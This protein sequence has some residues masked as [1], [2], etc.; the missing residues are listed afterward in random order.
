MILRKSL[1][2]AVRRGL[3][4]LQGSKLHT[5]AKNV[6]KASPQL[7]R[8][9]KALVAGFP[10]VIPIKMTVQGCMLDNFRNTPKGDH[11]MGMAKIDSF[12]LIRGTKL[13][14]Q[15]IDKLFQ[16][17]VFLYKGSMPCTT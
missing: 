6:L 7:A 8:K 2:V 15:Q 17:A 1:S 4:L 14:K 16:L 12:T 13:N 11:C 3:V 5:P 10:G 9:I